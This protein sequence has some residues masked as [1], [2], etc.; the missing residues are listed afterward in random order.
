MSMPKSN[1]IYRGFGKIRALVIEIEQ[2][3]IV[4]HTYKQ[5][6]GRHFPKTVKSCSGHPKRV[7]LSKI[8]K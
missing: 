3:K 5:R 8:L 6:R 4:S 7:N 2:K 1:R